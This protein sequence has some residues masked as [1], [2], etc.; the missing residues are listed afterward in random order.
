MSDNTPFFIIGSGRPGTTLL[1][2]VISGHSRIHIPPETWFMLPL[3]ERLPLAEPLSPAQVA[4]ALDIIAGH[5]RWPDMQIDA[6]DLRTAVADLTAPTLA[7]LVAPV[8]RHHLAAAGKPRAGDKT[9]HYVGIVPELATVYPGA[10]LIHLIRDGR[11]V[12]ISFVDARFRGRPY[13]GAR[14]EWTRAVRQGIAYRNSRYAAQ[15]LEVRYEDL[16][17][18]LAGTVHRICDFLGETFEPGMLH[19]QERIEQSLPA[20]ERHLHGK[21]TQPVSADAAAVWRRKLSAMECFLMEASLHRDLDRL[22]YRRR[23][24]PDPRRC[25]T[26]WRRCSTGRCRHCGGGISPACSTSDRAGPSPQRRPCAR[27]HRGGEQRV[28]AGAEQVRRIAREQR[29]VV[30]DIDRIQRGIAALTE[31]QLLANPAVRA[32]EQGEADD[33]PARARRA[34]ARGRGNAPRRG[35]RPRSSSGRTT[36]RRGFQGRAMPPP[37]RRSRGPHPARCGRRAPAPRR[38]EAQ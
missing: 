34:A 22:G 26:R 13:H 27:C 15:I 33:A 30:L 24:S 9:P 25:C 8:Y 3:V 4:A 7:A 14:F 1:R 35:S 31:P 19:F 16:V 37:R 29:A 36:A 12:A 5:D 18:D 2:M 32:V 6:A 17:A 38:R 11:D 28:Q 10:K 20:R 23:C 21:L